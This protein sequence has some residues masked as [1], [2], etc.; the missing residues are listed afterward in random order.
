[1][2]ATLAALVCF[3]TIG[4]VL[5]KAAGLSLRAFLPAL[6]LPNTG[7]LG[8][9]LALFAFGQ[10]GLNYAVAFFAIVSICNHTIGQS[11]AAGRGHWR[12]AIASPMVWA[13]LA[14]IAWG[15]AKIPL[16]VW[17]DNTLELMSGLTIPLLLLMVGTSLARIPVK[18]V[19]R[20]A[21]LSMVRIG[22]G[23]A[24][25][26]GLSELFGFTGAER[27]AFVLQCAMPVAVY[28]YV[29]AQLYNTAPEEV[30]SLVVLSTIFSAFT[31]PVLLTLLT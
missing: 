10:Q 14:G 16:P 18:S 13:A 24:V 7:N 17:F 20:A 5:L 31:V 11:I 12:A 8:L 15:F 25:G 30:A 23:I 1:M 26:F 9:P 3:L 19:P 28:N 2:V 6:A 21:V 22:M 29:Y 27:G 4:T